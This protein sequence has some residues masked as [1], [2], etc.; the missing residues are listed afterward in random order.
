MIAESINEPAIGDLNGDGNDDIVVAT[1]ETYD[2]NP[3]SDE[4]IGGLFAQGL[5]DLLA[6]AAGGSSRVYAVDGASGEFLPGWPIQLNGAIQDTLPLIGPGQDPAIVKI[7]G[8]TRIVASTTGSATIEESQARRLAGDQR[9]AG[10]L[11]RGLG[12][13]R[14]HRHDQPLRVRLD[15]QALPGSPA[16]R[17]SSTGSR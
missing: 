17:S 11:R 7:G 8:Q 15:R 5:S 2:A 4:D 13:H 9:P 16:R 1:N 3:P 12:R 10:R 14:P 6:G